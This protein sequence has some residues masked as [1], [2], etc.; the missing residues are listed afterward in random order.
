MLLGD[1]TRLLKEVG[2]TTTLRQA[3][4][5]AIHDRQREWFYDPFELEWAERNEERIIKELTKELKD[6]LNYEFKPA[7]AYFPPKTDLCYRRM[8]YIPFKDLVVR[9]AFATVVGDLIDSDLSR[10]CFANRR[11]DD[12]QAGRLLQ[13]FASVSWPTFCEWQRINKGSNTYATLLR[14]DISAFYDSISHRYLIKEVASN[15]K[16]PR[17]SRLMKLFRL[18][19]QVPVLSYCHLTRKQRGPETIF[20]GLSIGNSTEGLYANIYLNAIDRDMSK[21]EGIDF[22][23]YNDDMRVFA[24]DRVTAKQAMLA[25]QERLLTKGLNLNSSKTEF[26]EGEAA[27]ERLR[28]RAYEADEY[29]DDD[30]PTIISRPEV[31][32]QPF[33]EFERAFEIG[34]SIENAK[35]AKDFCHFLAKRTI[36]S[37]RQPG[38]V[39]MLHII[40]TDWHGSAK[41]AAW[42]LVET[43]VRD[44]CSKK[45]R[46]LAEKALL[47]CLT[48]PKVTNYGKYRLLHHLVRARRPSS[49]SSMRSYRY[50]RKLKGS[51][52]RELKDLLPRF[53][54]EPAFELN[55]IAL[56]AMRAL[57]GS[58]SDLQNA[59]EVN[60]CKPVPLPIRNALMLARRPP[61]SKSFPNYVPVEDEEAEMENNY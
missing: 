37:E 12:P 41:H 33:D 56:Y 58:S 50:W 29:S 60:A 31:A 14:T 52:I 27:V 23:R 43:I 35:D 25:L 18:L 24:I 55:I 8:I 5:Y 54:A 11:D 38:H 57:G 34:Q 48:D 36:F 19:L 47:E 45:T 61:K 17:G 3:F 39:R 7:Y 40:L 42:R 44:E 1:A 28:S 49:F 2:K 26:A 9:Y 15:L 6:P 22:G 10:N 59:V 13:D 4:Q 21:F 30:G 46:E 51:T 53:L 16:V 20:Q 32:D